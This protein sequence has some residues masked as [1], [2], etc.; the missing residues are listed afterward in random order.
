MQTFGSNIYNNTDSL[1][2]H[3]TT[4]VLPQYFSASQLSSVLTAVYGRNYWTLE[5]QG[6]IE[7]ANVGHSG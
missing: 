2:P 7:N 1:P 5:T 3:P 6:P 4:E